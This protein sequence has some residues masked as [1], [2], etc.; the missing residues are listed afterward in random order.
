MPARLPALIERLDSRV[1]L[2]GGDPDPAFNDG[3]LVE[4]QFPGGS[5]VF[6]DVE[7]L[8]DGSI[9]AA[10]TLTV[11]EGDQLTNQTKLLLAKYRFDGSLDPDFGI[12]GTIVNTPRG[13]S[14]A[15]Q[16]ALTDGGFFVLGSRGS[17]LKFESTG[18][19]DRTFGHDARLTP[20]NSAQAIIVDPEGRL[21]VGGSRAHPG[22]PHNSVGWDGVIQRYTSDGI[23]DTTFNNTG[24]FIS[25]VPILGE[26]D[27]DVKIFRSFAIDPQGRVIAGLNRFN[28]FGGGDNG[29]GSELNYL[30]RFN[31]D[32]SLD[33]DYGQQIIGG[34]LRLVSGVTSDGSVMLVGENIAKVDPTGQQLDTTYGNNGIANT[35][36]LG[37]FPGDYGLRARDQSAVSPDGSVVYTNVAALQDTT[38]AGSLELTR[39][40]AAGQ[41]DT[42]FGT[43][44]TKVILQSTHADA[45]DF[46]DAVELSPDGT[47]V[48]AGQT[49]YVSPPVGEHDFIAD[50]TFTITADTRTAT[51]GRMLLNDNPAVQLVPRLLTTPQQSLYVSVY[52]RDP[53]GV[54]LDSLDDDDLKLVDPAGGTR[55]FRFVSSED[56]SGDGTTI[57]ARYRIPAPTTDGWTSANN[58]VY[59]IR[60]AKQQIAG[61]DANFAMGQPLGSVTVKIA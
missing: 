10:G 46:L 40:T 52:L 24:E 17:I 45:Q 28:P 35:T 7:T 12:D 57:Q 59:E 30:F 32:G 34:T 21:V 55:R 19:L 16:L 49:G 41:L 48:F 15:L 5:S 27:A 47:L 39:L 22:E 42:N 26:E 54:D 60:L 43:N 13:V 6:T 53:A 11:V 51:V 44:G 37:P 36:K 3:G 20:D 58:G 33:A 18:R 8:A 38:L 2:S 29:L 4:Q 1:L 31:S 50:P 23:L 14:T 61:D 9:L 25:E 56:V